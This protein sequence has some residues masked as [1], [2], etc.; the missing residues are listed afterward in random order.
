MIIVN[1]NGMSGVHFQPPP[2]PPAGIAPK[3]PPPRA[4]SHFF[5]DERY[6]LMDGIISQDLIPYIDTHF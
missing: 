2:P 3:A 6:A 1:E 5:T 4:V